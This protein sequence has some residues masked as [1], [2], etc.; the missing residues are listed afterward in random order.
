MRYK[1]ETQ[2]Q[3][4]P[5]REHLALTKAKTVCCKNSKNRYK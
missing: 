3:V 4:S 5:A 1:T 2:K